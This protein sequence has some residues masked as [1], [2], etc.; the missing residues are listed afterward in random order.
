MWR[1]FGKALSKPRGIAQVLFSVVGATGLAYLLFFCPQDWIKSNERQES[2]VRGLASSLL[3][4]GGIELLATFLQAASDKPKRSRFETFFGT[5]DHQSAIAV[6]PSAKLNRNKEDPHFNPKFNPL[7]FDNAPEIAKNKRAK[8]D[9]YLV[10]SQD[11]QATLDL[12][13]TFHEFDVDFK[14]A[15]DLDRSLYERLPSQRNCLIAIGLGFNNLTAQIMDFHKDSNLFEVIFVDDTD[16][17]LIGGERH[18]SAAEGKKDY[19]LLVR[20]SSLTS[21]RNNPHFVCAGRTANG[22][23]AAGIFLAKEWEQL[24]NLYKKHQKDF[25]SDSLAVLIEFEGSATY[26]AKISSALLKRPMNGPSCFFVGADGMSW[27]S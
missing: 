20:E 13:E 2:V 15:L 22:T 10:V 18:E 4:V 24:Y 12:A 17:F 25:G 9:E 16:D 5:S 27:V 1:T 21:G 14:T 8:G 6:F 19:A 11:L 23:K 7:I 3:L 26:K